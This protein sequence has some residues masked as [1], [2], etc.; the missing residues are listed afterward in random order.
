MG[1]RNLEITTG[2]VAQ[3]ILANHHGWGGFIINA[4]TENMWI[5]F[6][7]DAAEDAGELIY[8]GSPAKFSYSEF[9]EL[10]ARVSIF[11]ATTGAKFTLRPIG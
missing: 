9:P 6:G 4:L 3:D 5:N 11:S 2:G 7:A 1:I 8:Q 10:N